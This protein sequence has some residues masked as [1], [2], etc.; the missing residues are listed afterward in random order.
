MRLSHLKYFKFTMVAL[1][2][3]SICIST[4]KMF[5]EHPVVSETDIDTALL[6]SNFINVQTVAVDATE[7]LDLCDVIHVATFIQGSN[8]TFELMIFLKSILANRRNPLHL[9][10][11]VK[12]F[13]T[14][15]VVINML[16]SW[17]VV[18][19]DFSLYEIENY[20]SDR[21]SW[22]SKSFHSNDQWRMSIPIVLSHIEK[23]IV[24]DVNMQIIGNVAIL[25][26]KLLEMQKIGTRLGLVEIVN[27]RDIPASTSLEFDKPIVVIL[28]FLI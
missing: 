25:W 18:G 10:L 12:D 4:W 24:A 20:I 28:F 26:N 5:V 23:V 9:H 8:N 15:S 6:E 22:M 1:A 11:F 14:K 16:D 2:T 17:N 3:L 27:S 13:L 19:V 21:Q 7:N